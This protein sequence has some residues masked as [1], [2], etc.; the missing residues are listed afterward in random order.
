MGDVLSSYTYRQG[1]ENAIGGKVGAVMWLS[2]AFQIIRAAMLVYL[3]ILF[4]KLVTRG[5]KALDLYIDE[6][7]NIK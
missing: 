2:A 5:I 3:F 7:T 6:K 4:V 1:I